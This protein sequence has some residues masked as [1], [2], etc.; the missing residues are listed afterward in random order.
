MDRLLLNGLYQLIG[1]TTNGEYRLGDDCDFGVPVP[2]TA[3]ISGVL[4]DGDR[5]VGDRTSN[6]VMSIPVVVIGTSATDLALKVNRIIQTVDSAAFT[7]A[8]TPAG[9]MTVIYD[10]YRGSWARERVPGRDS[11]FITVIRITFP[12]SPF[13]RSDSVETIAVASPQLPIDNMATAPTNTTSD[14]VVFYEGTKSAKLTLTRNGSAGAGYW[15]VL[16]LNAVKT[17]LSLDLTGYTSMSVRF[18]WPAPA[19]YV[20]DWTVY[21]AFYLSDGTHTAEVLASLTVAPGATDWKLVTVS[22]ADFLAADPA[23]NLAAITSYQI[24]VSTY[25]RYTVGTPGATVNAWIDDVRAYPSSSSSMTS[26]NGAVLTVPSVKG[27]ARAPLSLTLSGVTFTNGVLVHSPPGSQ[28]PDAPVVSAI[29]IG[30]PATLTAG[31]NTLSGTY[32][33]VLLIGTAGSG[34]RTVTLTIAQKQGATTLKTETLTQPIVGTPP[35]GKFLEMGSVTLPLVPVPD[36]NTGITYV[37]TVTSGATAGTYT[38]LVLCDSQGQFVMVTA[39][40]AGTT[41]IYIDAPPAISDVA[42]IY[43]TA[44]D[45]T[46]AVAVRSSVR[47]SG[48]GPPFVEPGDNRIV[49]ASPNGLPTLSASYSP[50]WLDE[51]DV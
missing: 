33:I 4:L 23:L 49:V 13:G 48:G 3:T 22:L 39:P 20:A 17:G 44:S 40:L 5:V 10:G 2:D 8:W 47:D 46:A 26:T 29:G 14:A 31:A 1:P 9:G 30:S 34:T 7:L 43:G 6:R 28:D 35:T 37:F 21:L 19:T 16:P 36:E 50:H 41:S 32:G 51:R 42:P 45:R 24:G 25:L 15:Y 18:R 27:T 38:D 11:R 12:A